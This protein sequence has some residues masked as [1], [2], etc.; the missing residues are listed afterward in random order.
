M[1]EFL[2]DVESAFHEL[3]ESG[4]LNIASSRDDPLTFGNADVLLV[5]ATFR[6]RMLCDRGDTSSD[7]ASNA[8]PNDWSPLERVLQAVGAVGVP[9]EGLLSPAQAARLVEQHFDTLNQGLSEANLGETRN[10]LSE[11][12]R[13]RL[14][15]ASSRLKPGGH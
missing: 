2:R 6:L 11:I 1:R 13:S 15:L 9:E 7:I 10:R 14:E 5:G 12:K 3:M 4:K 8:L